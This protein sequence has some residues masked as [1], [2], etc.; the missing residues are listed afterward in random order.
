[1][2]S[3]TSTQTTVNGSEIIDNDTLNAPRVFRKRKTIGKT[4]APAGHLMHGAT[5][6]AIA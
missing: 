1:M 5:L 6:V 2:S 3:S 4:R